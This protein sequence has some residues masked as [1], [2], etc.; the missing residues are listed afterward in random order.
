M[1]KLIHVRK[2][3]LR[4]L[5]SFLDSAMQISRSHEAAVVMVAIA[6]YNLE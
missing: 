5:S 2:A 1:A 6:S 3:L 4:L